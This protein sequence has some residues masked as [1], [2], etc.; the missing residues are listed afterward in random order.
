MWEHVQDEIGGKYIL[1]RLRNQLLEAGRITCSHSHFPLEPASLPLGENIPSV[2][3][4]VEIQRLGQPRCCKNLL[5]LARAIARSRSNNGYISI[6]VVSMMTGSA[7]GLVLALPF[8]LPVRLA[9]NVVV[10][11]IGTFVVVEFRHLCG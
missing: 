4:L 5:F 7:D 10:P 1:T 9:V 8:L 3:R 11:G 2:I 6:D